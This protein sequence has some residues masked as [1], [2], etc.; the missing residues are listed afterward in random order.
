MF[1][2]LIAHQLGERVDHTPEIGCGTGFLSLWMAG[3]KK[4]RTHAY[5]GHL[6]TEI[7]RRILLGLDAHLTHDGTAFIFSDSYI[8]DD[9]T[10]TL[11]E[12][13]V[14]LLGAQPWQ[15]TATQVECQPVGVIPT[16]TV[17]IA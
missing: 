9:G 7:T 10:D 6:G 16:S 1:R 3:R 5:G 8:Q 4:A 14:E 13:L 12:L 17:G 11:C 15:V 2:D